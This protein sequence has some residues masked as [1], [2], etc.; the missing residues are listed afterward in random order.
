MSEITDDPRMLALIENARL[1]RERRERR[2]ARIAQSP[3]SGA[4]RFRTGIAR[5]VRDSWGVDAESDGLERHR[6]VT[7]DGGEPLLLV[8][9]GSGARNFAVSNADRAAFVARGG[10]RVL[11]VQRRG[12]RQL[13]II[14]WLPLD[15]I[16]WHRLVEVTD[17]YP[18]PTACRL[19]S[20]YNLIG[21][22]ATDADPPSV[23]GRPLAL[24][25]L[26]PEITAFGA[27]YPRSTKPRRAPARRR[28][29]PVYAPVVPGSDD[30]ID[31]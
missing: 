23:G 13:R 12:G 25:R 7:A 14:A 21:Q 24:D 15:A 4:D 3:T 26:P 22:L 20:L 8:V 30:E 27:R 5:E 31:F 19:A 11:F 29:A 16:E 28:T 1:K 2:M 10:K 18:T 6:V 17:F 9:A